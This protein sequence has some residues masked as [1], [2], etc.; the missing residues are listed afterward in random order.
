MYGEV[1]VAV[2]VEIKG[3]YIEKQQSCFVCVT[4]KSWSGWKILDP[5]SYTVFVFDGKFWTHPRIHNQIYRV[6]SY[7]KTKTRTR[8]GVFSVRYEMNLY[9]YAFFW[10]IPRRLNFI[11]RRFGTLCLFHLHRQVEWTRLGTCLGYYKGKGLARKWPE[12][13]GRKGRE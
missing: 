7:N 1:N 10:V 12:P 6:T 9:L 3:D 4:L 8:R 11:F 13:L 2:C 5:P